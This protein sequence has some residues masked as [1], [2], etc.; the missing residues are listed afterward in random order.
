[1]FLHMTVEENLEMGGYTQP[2]AT[3]EGEPGKGV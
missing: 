1:V 2:Q 3:I